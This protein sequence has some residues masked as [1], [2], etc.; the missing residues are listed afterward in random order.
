MEFIKYDDVNTDYWDSCID[1]L[2]N[3][4]FN[5][6]SARIEFDREYS[7]RII[8]N[9]SFLVKVDKTMIGVCLIFIEEN[10][11]GFHQ[12]SWADRYCLAPYI[13]NSITYKNQEKY[14]KDIF[15]YIINISEKYNCA[16][17]Y[18]RLDPLINPEQK[19]K[20]CNYNFLLK[21]NFI[22]QSSLSQIIDLRK[23]ESE[24]FSDV[25][26]G[27]RSSLK[28]GADFEIEIYDSSNMIDD[29]IEIYRAI[30]EYDAG[31]VTR[32]SEMTHHFLKFIKAGNA[33][34]G[35]AKLKG[36]YVG[37][38]LATFYK[39]T[40]YYF[41]YAEMT[42]KLEGKSVGHVLQWSTIKYLKKIGIEFY[43]IGEQVFGKTHYSMPDPKLINISLFKRGFG[44]YTVPF[45]RGVR[46]NNLI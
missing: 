14:M 17:I 12:I 6:R 18:F 26:K 39:N 37:V 30:Y 24:L 7:N 19:D 21:Y 45:Y 25:R 2:D 28:A 46:D 29:K 10:D 35:F 9:E 1:K 5:Y 43:E 42:D 23:E 3:C 4:S 11:E 36:E 20:L 41:S 16:H 15:D 8:A 40:A 38:I 34:L 44:G 13:S 32:N 27:H 33:V 31:R 22:D